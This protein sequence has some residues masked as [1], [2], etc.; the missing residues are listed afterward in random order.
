MLNTENTIRYCVKENLSI[1]VVISK[2]DRLILELKL[3][4][5]DA[6]LKI[7]HTLEEINGIIQNASYHLK[8]SNNDPTRMSPLLG[9]VAFSSGKY[10][11]VFSIKSFA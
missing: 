6:Y 4:P 11:F 1:T 10:G 2:M 8:N 3:P 5:A 7:K 9:N